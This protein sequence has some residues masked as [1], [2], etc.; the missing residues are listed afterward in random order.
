MILGGQ[1]LDEVR[2][3]LCFVGDLKAGDKEEDD[4]E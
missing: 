1:R 2:K 3:E 4:S